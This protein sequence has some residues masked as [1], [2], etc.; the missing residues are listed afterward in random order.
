MV[1]I[2][3][4]EDDLDLA[5]TIVDY[6]DIED[7]ECDHAS[8]GLIGLNLIKTNSYQMIILDI[9]MP[10]MDGLTLCKLLREEGIDTPVLFLTARDSLDNKLEG[11][12]AG[13][14]DYLVKPF[15]MK[16]LVARVSVLAKRK[17]GEAKRLSLA[18]LTVDLTQRSVVVKDKA[19]KL[20]PIAYK[21]LTTLIRETPKVVSRDAIMQAVWGDEIP[22]SN[23]LKVHIYHVRKQLESA[24][25]QIKLETIPSIGFSIKLTEET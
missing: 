15:A 18:D 5:T 25:D 6:L 10:K 4:V 9:N 23:S 12:S 24:T 3:L 17:S 2:L 20:S 13:S 7:I 1:N 22:D 11:F 14:D 8:N 16:E 21:I 19:L